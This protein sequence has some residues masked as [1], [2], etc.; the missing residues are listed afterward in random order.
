MRTFKYFFTFLLVTL[1]CITFAQKTAKVVGIILD[2]NNKPVEGVNVSYQTKT[3][4]TDPNGFYTITIPA[5]QKVI[6]VFTHTSLKSITVPVQ[7]K[8]GE[9][10]EYHLMMNDRAEQL[11][12]V[13][14]T[15]KSRRAQGIVTIRPEVIRKNPRDRKSTRLNSSHDLASRMPSSA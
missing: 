4:N 3:V 5:N 9:E 10:L 6:L 13:I 7:L 14:V 8:E 12:D 1:S 15:N 2:E 11:T